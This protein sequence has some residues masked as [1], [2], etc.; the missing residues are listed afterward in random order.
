MP[1][2]RCQINLIAMN[3]TVCM[4]PE[5]YRSIPFQASNLHMW[6]NPC[7]FQSPGGL[8]GFL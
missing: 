4:G 5:D 3:T 6:N 2:M 8:Q 7:S 1:Q